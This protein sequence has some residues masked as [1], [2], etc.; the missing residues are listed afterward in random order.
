M[1]SNIQLVKLKE[2]DEKTEWYT[3]D[4]YCDDCGKQVHRVGDIFSLEAPEDTDLC[5]SCLGV[6]MG[7]DKL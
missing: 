2:T 7:M 6:R 3:W 4:S 5:V 1:K